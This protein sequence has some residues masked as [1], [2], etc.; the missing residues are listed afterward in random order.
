MGEERAWTGAVA[1]ALRVQVC[2]ISFI[3]LSAHTTGYSKVDNARGSCRKCG[4]SG[5][6]TF[7]CRNFVRLQQA[8]EIVL[9][10]SST[11]SEEEAPTPLTQP[12]VSSL[13]PSKETIKR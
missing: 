10:V 12:V 11:S 3:S 8:S 13:S 9:D 6:L 2:S 5:H 4:Y 1:E 7:Q